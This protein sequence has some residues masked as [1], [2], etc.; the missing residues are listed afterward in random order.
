M[1]DDAPRKVLYVNTLY[2]P[3]NVGGAEATVRMLA[4]DH[5]RRGGEA[6]VVTLSPTG[7]ADTEEIAGVR[8]RRLPLANLFFLHDG[9]RRAPVW[10][11]LWHAVDAWN[12]VMA[13][14]LG[15]VLDAEAPDLVH[16]HNLQGFSVSAW[17]A[18][19]LRRRPLV[20]TLHDYYTACSNS[21]MFREGRNCAVP[22]VACRLLGAA[23]WR[24]SDRPHVV[25]AVSRR[26]LDRVRAAGVF[27]RVADTRVIPN[28]NA[29]GT[30]RPEDA[31]DRP[32]RPLRLGF[33]GRLEP[34][35]GVELLCEAFRRLPPGAATL[36]I[37]GTGAEA[38][39]SGLRRRYDGSGIRFAGWV[40]PDV[41][42]P[43][44]D[45]LVVPSL[46]E[47]PLSRVSHEALEHGVPVI[48]ARTGGIPEVVRDGDTGRLFCPGDSDDLE[49]ALR[50]LLDSGRDWRGLSRRCRNQAA[51]FRLDAIHAAYRDAYG[52]AR[53]AACRS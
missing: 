20:Q 35:K 44:L 48:G 36:T 40:D 29:P 9:V 53:T 42:L 52:A 10:R 16:A 37:G 8:V 30:A 25:T 19:A 27:S 41:F 32:G 49:G 47:E 22:C 43:G 12:P 6:V 45:A 23:R 3:H 46:W 2:H 26:L 28:A 14:R 24:L 51:R 1:A 21:A 7:R 5:V 50:S 31:D 38:Y 34:V 4:E 17:E 11:R 13:D 15:R 33:L 39:V 18:V